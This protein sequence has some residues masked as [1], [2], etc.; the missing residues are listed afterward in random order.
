MNVMVDERTAA[1]A[2]AVHPHFEDLRQVAA[3]LAGLLVL[4]ATGSKDSSPDHPMLSASKQVLAQAD[5]GV[6]RAGGLVSERTRPHYRALVD[7]SLAL[8]QA[9]S[10]ADVAPLD[11]DAVMIPLRD[12][13]SR[14]QRATVALPGFQIVS[15]E[16]ACCG[17]RLK[18]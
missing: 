17:T 7:A 8:R 15:F 3:Q 9:L 18:T 14:L 11:V 2:V 5:D 16:Q 1:Y 10:R 12:A 13:Y 4:A 6:R